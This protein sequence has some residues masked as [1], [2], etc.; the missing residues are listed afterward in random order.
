MLKK[1]MLLGLAV[2]AVTPLLAVQG[3]IT[4]ASDTRKGDIRWQPRSRTYYISF[5]KGQSDMSAEF[6]L[7]EVVS[8][9]IDK[10]AGYDRAV[11]SVMRGQGG[12]AIATL[13]K[14][15]AD[16]RMLVWDK[17]AG[18]Y[19]ALAYLA[20]GQAQEALNV[21]Q[22]IIAEDKAAAYSGELASAYWQS[23]LK[24]GKIQQL[25]AVLKK[26]AAADDRAASAA[27]L[28]MRG[29]I[30]MAEGDSREVTERALRD[31]YLRV[32][33]MYGDSACRR[34]RREALMK[35]AQ[36]FDKLKYTE[37]AERLRK[38]LAQLD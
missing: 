25:E 2:L 31:G 1:S 29:D 36:C 24:L 14:I 4:T 22:S 15:V 20:D 21:C 6:K 37:R 3:T 5:R 26:A 18:R 30:I 23:L 28:V 32:V 10:P 13:K 33:L 35:A 12:S 16:Y 7:A 19:L 17:P 8:L 11:E 27:A 38:Q 9:D 34:E